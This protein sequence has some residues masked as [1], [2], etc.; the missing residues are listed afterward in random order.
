MVIIEYVCSYEG[1]TG[2]LI[3]TSNYLCF[4]PL[5]GGGPDS[6][7]QVALTFTELKEIKKKRVM[8]VFAAMEV[9]TDDDK[10]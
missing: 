5:V 4:D 9:T 10:V 1:K 6:E 8:L 2:W 7:H 3:L